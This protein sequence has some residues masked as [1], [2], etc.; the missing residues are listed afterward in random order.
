MGRM[1]RRSDFE[2]RLTA[3][4]PMAAV[5]QKMASYHIVELLG[6]TGL[7][8]IVIDT[9]HAPY[10]RSQ[11]DGCLLASCAADIPAV[12][13]I[14]QNAPACILSVLDMGACG[15]LVPHVFSVEQARA[16]VASTRYRNGTR[17]FSPSTRAGGYGTVVFDEYI[18]ASDREIA[19][20]LQI[21]DAAAVDVIDAISSVKGVSGL[22]VGRA[23]L[24]LSMGLDWENSRL[25][26]VCR[27][28]AEAARKAGIA[29]GAY[30]PHT[31][32]LPLFREWGFSFFIIGSDQSALK[33]QV[34]QD[35]EAFK[36]VACFQGANRETQ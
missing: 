4:A 33:A 2:A 8:F 31:E 5:F 15:I 12:V 20:L 14:E 30:L 22:F 28:T 18:D 10:D 11:L 6:Q 9:E 13:R 25:D 29:A 17:G 7:D 32:R 27:C 36:A 1:T 23:D 16:A 26:K 21:E 35:F 34:R 24:A 3:K 19:V